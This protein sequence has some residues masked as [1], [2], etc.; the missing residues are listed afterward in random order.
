MNSVKIEHNDGTLALYSGFNKDEIYVNI[1]D[2]VYIQNIMHLGKTE[3]YD[4]R[5]KHRINF[6]LFYYSTKKGVK[7]IRSI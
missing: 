6:S 1:G 5:K 2:I 3:V 4:A 7:I